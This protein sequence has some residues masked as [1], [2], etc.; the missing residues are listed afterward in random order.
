[1][2]IAKHPIPDPDP[3]SHHPGSRWR[4]SDEILFSLYYKVEFVFLT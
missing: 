2:E 4:K 3:D 1:M